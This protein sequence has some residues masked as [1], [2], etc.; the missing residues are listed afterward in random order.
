MLNW[1]DPGATFTGH[2]DE[3]RNA[4]SDVLYSGNYILGM[5][6]R[7]FEY[8]FSQY[9]DAEHGIGVANGTDALTIALAA[10]GI[11]S[12][13]EVITVS[14]TSPATI[15][16]IRLTGAR[17]VYIDVNKYGVM[18]P[19]KIEEAITPKTAAIVPVHLYGCPADM[20]LICKI[21]E[22]HDLRV[23]EDCA[24]AAG[25]SWR[26]KPVGSWGDAGCFSFY[27]TKNLGAFGDGGMIVT[28]SHEIS[29]SAKQLRQYGW[30]GQER[31]CRGRGL[32]SRLD[33][34]QA[35]ILNVKLKYLDKD[36]EYR[37]ALANRYRRA[38]LGTSYSVPRE[39][40]FG[41]HSYSL[42]VIGHKQ[43]DDVIGELYAQGIQCGIHYD[44]PC[45]EHPH[46]V[47]DRP[48]HLPWTD[49]FARHVLSLPIHPYLTREKQDW[50]IE[51]LLE[52]EEE[53]T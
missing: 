28:D 37:R 1:T 33:E 53:L 30:H 25:S 42:Y 20:D 14:H 8:R 31:I 18:N 29:Q 49:V 32:N 34:I 46:L 47:P 17:P 23:I 40:E 39:P 13:H 51:A 38:L 52:A 48:V 2:S 16:A 10:C 9:C 6:V 43:R 41:V 24:Q 11:R 27:P 36:V 4:V 19:A 7:E 26:G 35:A 15:C 44:T 50:V 21:A 5:Q 45:H 22:A 12:G 3:I